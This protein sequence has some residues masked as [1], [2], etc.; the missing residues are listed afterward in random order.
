M[1]FCG[2]CKSLVYPKDGVMTCKKCGWSSKGPVK[3]QVI[4]KAREKTEAVVIE[5]QDDPR[6]QQ[7]IECPKC[8]HGKAYFK[9]MQTRKSDEPE[10]Q[11][12]E[13]VECHHSWREY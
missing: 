1:P 8:G 6:P 3:S 13:C 10:T 7:D 4:T 9:L 12:N 11:I 5:K 2:D